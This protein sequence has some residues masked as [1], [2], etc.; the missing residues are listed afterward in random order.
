MRVVER[1][2][3]HRA[4][5]NHC[6]SALPIARTGQA[7]TSCQGSGN[8]VVLL[9]LP[10]TQGRMMGTGGGTTGCRHADPVSISDGRGDHRRHGIPRHVPARDLGRSEIARDQ[11][12]HPA[13]PVRQTT[14]RATAM[15]RAARQADTIA[16][17]LDMLSAE[18]GAGTNTLDAYRRDLNDFAT[19]LGKGSVATA[20]T[21]D[22]RDYLGAL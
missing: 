4:T 19:Y 8:V 17:F 1:S 22:L 3:R 11:R 13:G 20:T 15:A 9:T 12:H 7:R 10:G 14:L 5:S 6:G 21:E 18:R 2:I 16:L